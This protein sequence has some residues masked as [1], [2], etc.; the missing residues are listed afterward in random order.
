MLL[1]I[2]CLLKKN[3]INIHCWKNS[4]ILISQKLYNCQLLPMDELELVNFS[5]NLEDKNYFTRGI[6]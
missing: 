6:Y 5:L 3:K 2:K 4:K 1:I